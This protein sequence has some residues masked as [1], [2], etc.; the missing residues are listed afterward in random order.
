MFFFFFFFFLLFYW[1]AEPVFKII[2]KDQTISSKVSKNSIDFL[3]CLSTSI[4]FP[5]LLHSIGFSSLKIPT[6]WRICWFRLSI[7]STSWRCKNFFLSKDGN[8]FYNT[9][10]FFLFCSVLFFL[11]LKPSHFIGHWKRKAVPLLDKHP[12]YT[13]KFFFFESVL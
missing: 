9:F 13:S 12:L 8:F 10:S 6:Q 4:I 1:F 5:F 7:H 2:N 3:F 11:Y